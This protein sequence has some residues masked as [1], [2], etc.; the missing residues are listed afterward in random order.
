MDL[1]S[2]TTPH[3]GSDMFW[4]SWHL[5]LT[6]ALRCY[7]LGSTPFSGQECPVVYWRG[8]GGEGLLE[9]WGLRIEGA[10]LCGVLAVGWK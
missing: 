10:I 3:L 7:C 8:G 9:E 6:S 2:R 1:D 5:I 4:V